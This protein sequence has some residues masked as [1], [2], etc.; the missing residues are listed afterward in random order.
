MIIGIDE[1]TIKVNKIGITIKEMGILINGM[2]IRMHEPTI[3]IKVNKTATKNNP[4]Y[5]T[6]R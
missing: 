5:N 1:I 2:A 6:H 3:T 4:N